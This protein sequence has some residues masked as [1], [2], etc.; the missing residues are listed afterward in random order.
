[1]QLRIYNKIIIFLFISLLFF[2]C[3]PKSKYDIKLDHIDLNLE[4]NRFD[5]ELAALD[6]QNYET[7]IIEISKKYPLIFEVFVEQIA[8]AGRLEDS[9]FLDRLRPI[10]FDKY[11][12]EL[13]KKCE[14]VF[15]DFNTVEDELEYAYKHLLHYY[16]EFTIPEVYSIISNF[17]VA[18]ASFENSIMFSLEYY[19]GD[20]FPA[21]DGLFPH[22][23]YKHFKK[24]YL[25]ADIMKVQFGALYPEEE[26]AGNNLLSKMIYEGKKLFFLEL[27]IPQKH[28]SIRIGYGKDELKWC[29][30]NEGKIWNQFLESKMLYETQTLQISK[31]LDDGPFTNAIG[32]PQD[33]P[34]RLGQWIGWQIVRNYIERNAISDFQMLFEEK[35][36]QKILMQ[37]AYKPKI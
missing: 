35:D 3:K 37:S 8:R 1:M 32:F 26:Y 28:D 9:L 6:E 10:F 25:I 29:A 20:A 14:D 30:K 36:A 24:D 16:P 23:K 11:T 22:Y 5:Q 33:S 34:P 2:A 19:L 18:A 7:K 27:M 31:Y 13:Y 4:V 17:G 21:Y 15:R 12:Q